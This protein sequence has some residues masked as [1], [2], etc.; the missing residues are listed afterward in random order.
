MKKRL[1]KESLARMLNQIIVSFLE[2]YKKIKDVVSLLKI[3]IYD[4]FFVLVQIIWFTKFV[5]QTKNK[6]KKG[7]ENEK[8][9]WFV[10]SNF[11]CSKY[12][13]G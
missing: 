5:V 12:I 6:I 11:V 3:Q 2:F 13:N 10:Y 4:V 9:N 8:T 7:K 1:T